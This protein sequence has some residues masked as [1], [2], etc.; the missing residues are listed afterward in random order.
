MNEAKG[1]IFILF[2]LTQECKW[3]LI[4]IFKKMVT[5]KY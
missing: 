5:L 2:I 4:Y 3:L 1:R